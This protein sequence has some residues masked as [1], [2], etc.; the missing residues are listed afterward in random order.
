MNTTSGANARRDGIA[1]AIGL[2]VLLI[3]TASGSALVML[4]LSIIGMAAVTFMYRQRI[5]PR[6]VFVVVT[7]MCVAFA[8]AFGMALTQGV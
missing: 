4:I 3:G 2:L 1:V 6:L 7:A 5:T 8:V